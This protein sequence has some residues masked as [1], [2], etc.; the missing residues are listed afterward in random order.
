MIFSGNRDQI[1][2]HGFHKQEQ[3]HG[4]LGHRHQHRLAEAAGL[5]EMT[6]GA[7]SIPNYAYKLSFYWLV[8]FWKLT[9]Y[10][11][12]KMNT[13]LNIGSRRY[14]GKQPGI[15][16]WEDHEHQHYFQK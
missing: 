4:G 10:T 12:A 7:G 11:L 13:Y 9:F 6:M 5:N 3:W 8:I 1:Y 14:H 2:H 16:S 15:Q